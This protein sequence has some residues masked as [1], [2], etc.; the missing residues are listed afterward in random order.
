MAGV[1]V[2][3]LLRQE[4]HRLRGQQRKNASQPT[5]PQ[6]QIKGTFLLHCCFLFVGQ[7]L[8]YENTAQRAYFPF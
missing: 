3:Q 4:Y 2:M 5:E 8:I 6:H 1:C 7:L